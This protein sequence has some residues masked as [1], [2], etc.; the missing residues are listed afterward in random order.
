MA[1]LEDHIERILGE[2]GECLTA[3]EITLRLNGEVPGSR[4]PYTITE[5]VACAIRCRIYARMESRIVS[6]RMPFDASQ[7]RKRVAKSKAIERVSLK[8][9]RR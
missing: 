6:A 4:N 9:A 8:H 5:I 7:A 3:V 1:R 2:A